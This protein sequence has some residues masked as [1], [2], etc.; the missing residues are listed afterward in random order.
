M[1]TKTLPIVHK[2]YDPDDA[3][4]DAFGYVSVTGDRKFAEIIKE[5]YKLSNLSESLIVLCLRKG[6]DLDTIIDIQN[7]L[8]DH[9]RADTEGEK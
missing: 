7:L 9:I 6:K 2:Y 8:E 1:K 4:A 3:R 5:R